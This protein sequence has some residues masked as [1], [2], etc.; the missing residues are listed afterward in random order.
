MISPDDTPFARLARHVRDAGTGWSLGIFGAIAEFM[1]APDEPVRLDVAPDALTA[2][3][4]RGGLRVLAHGETLIVDYAMPSRHAERRV[5]AA[6]AC[7]PAAHAQRAGR[8][9]ITEL[10]PDAAALRAEDDGALLFDLGI[11]LSSV[12]AC[13]RTRA[14][15]LIAALRAAEGR[16]L[17][18]PDGPIG[19]I[20][21]HGPHRVFVSALGR[22]EVFQPIPPAGGRSPDG[23]H[24]HVLPKLLA[25]GRTHAASIPIP[26]GLVPCLSL[27][28]PAAAGGTGRA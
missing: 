25:H 17:L 9:T 18:A 1:R 21:A 11:G 3:T 4:A 7:L 16:P 19:A 13:V 15:D 14:P 22:I 26:A 12:E 5:P 27:H 2:V 24:T 20:L 8:T 28:P 23:P 10:G 6:A